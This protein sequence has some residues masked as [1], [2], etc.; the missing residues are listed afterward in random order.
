MSIHPDYEL[1]IDE[2][3][4]ELRN[5]LTLI[6]T[7]L[8]LIETQH[9]EAKEF[10][11]WESLSEEIL[12]MKAL[13]DD[14]TYYGSNSHLSLSTFSL[15]SLME[16]VSLSFAASIEDTDVEYV[17]KI[18]DSI[19]QITGDKT[20]LQEVF[21]NLLKNAFDASAPDGTIYFHAYQEEDEIIITIKDT[22]CGIS[23]ENLSTIFTPFVTYKKNGTGLGLPISKSILELHHGT[24]QVTSVVGQ[25]TMFKI[26]LPVNQECD[27]KAHK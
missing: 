12:Y 7:I 18:D 24:I 13:L 2:L 10:K 1:L 4:H 27:N 25:G 23:K 21:L 19:T 6:Y 11:H 9:P 26:T 16:Q 17:S 14:F 8:Q 22:G 15:R 3:S 20:K 5:P